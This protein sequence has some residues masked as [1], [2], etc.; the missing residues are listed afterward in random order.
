MQG[1]FEASEEDL[2][3]A[4]SEAE[5]LGY[6]VVPPHVL[7]ELGKSEHVSESLPLSP[8]AGDGAVGSSSPSGLADFVATQ[9]KVD[10]MAPACQAV[11]TTVPTT[12]AAAS[13]GEKQFIDAKKEEDDVGTAKV[14]VKKETTGTE[15]KQEGTAPTAEERQ[16]KKRGRPV[17]PHTKLFMECSSLGKQLSALATQGHVI[18]D[19][20]KPEVEDSSPWG[21]AK[22]DHLTLVAILKIVDVKVAEYQKY[23]NFNKFANVQKVHG[24]VERAT[25]YLET[26]NI[27]FQAKHQDLLDVVGPLMS[28][29]VA[30]ASYGH[31]TK[32]K[33]SS[34]TL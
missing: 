6:T 22:S 33:R 7:Q 30:R 26:L 4:G 3:S 23:I 5:L 1:D 19:M 13:L 12:L 9:R 20:S 15:V 21:W 24:S 28:M 27:E 29:K 25:E 34:D 31:N 18:A 11:A 2:K 10:I 16:Q 8:A 17:E 32:R 14:E